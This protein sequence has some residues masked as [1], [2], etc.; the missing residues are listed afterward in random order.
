[1]AGRR[2]WTSAAVVA[3]SM[4]AAAASAMSE[5]AIEQR[6]DDPGRRVDED[7]HPAAGHEA[8]AA[9]LRARRA[10]LLQEHVDAVGVGGPDERLVDSEALPG[11]AL[12]P[13]A[14]DVHARGRGERE[15]D[16][17][18]RHRD[19]HDAQRAQAPDA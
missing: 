4:V 17:V 18:G 2:R 14:R 6:D 11:L 8:H 15:G 19:P 13:R 16:V 9:H 1:M 3:A 5:K 10:R 7:A 12:E